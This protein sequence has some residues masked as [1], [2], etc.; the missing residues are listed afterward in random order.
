VTRERNEIVLANLGLAKAEANKYSNKCPESFDDLCQVAFI[1]LIKAAERFDS[2]RGFAFSSYAVPLIQGEIRHYL[3][4][5]CS[6]VRIPK[7][8]HATTEAAL[9]IDAYDG[10]LDSL[11]SP[12]V[13]P[14]AY[15]DLTFETLC[16]MERL[17]PRLRD[18]LT[19]IY[20]KGLT[21]QECAEKQ[22]VSHMTVSRDKKQ[23]F[24]WMRQRI[25]YHA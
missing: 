9:S 16:V 22:G 23:A 2:S 14:E 4:D 24:A 20:F 18:T 25:N 21:I 13:L 15:D 19:A 8:H 7:G 1:G 12:D 10:L 11:S 17:K 5:K 6:V 3:R